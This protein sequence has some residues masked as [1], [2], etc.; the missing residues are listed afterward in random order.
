METGIHRRF[1]MPWVI[2]PWLALVK[3]LGLTAKEHNKHDDDGDSNDNDANDNHDGDGDND[4]GEVEHDGSDKDDNDDDDDVN[5]DVIEDD[6]DDGTMTMRWRR[7]QMDDNDAMAMG[8]QRHAKISR[9]PR[10]PSETT[11]NICRQF[12]EESTRERDNFAGGDDK[13]DR[14]GG[15]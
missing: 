2:P 4:D 3:F 7:G 10:H 8:G 9:V 6:D 5:I 1:P 12:G 14:D 13:K 11:I 15:D